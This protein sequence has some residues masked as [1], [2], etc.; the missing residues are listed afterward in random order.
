MFIKNLSP[1][2]FKQIRWLVWKNSKNMLR[3]PYEIK[4]RLIQ[5]IVSEFNI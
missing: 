5:T 1:T 2:I 3:N 4:I